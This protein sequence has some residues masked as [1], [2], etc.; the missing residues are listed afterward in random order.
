MSPPAPHPKVPPPVPP[1]P[2]ILRRPSRR[3]GKLLADLSSRDHLI[4]DPVF[5]RLLG[6]HDEVPIR[7]LLDLVQ[8]LP[9]VPGKDLVEQLPVPEDLL[10]LDL[11]VHGLTTRL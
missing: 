3:G 9:G 6:G 8:R 1:A 4:D 2:G 5:L 7:V 11:D 10:G